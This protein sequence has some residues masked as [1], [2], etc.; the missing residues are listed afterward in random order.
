MKISSL[1]LYPV[2]KSIEEEIKSKFDK[3]YSSN[4]FLSGEENEKFEDEYAKFCNTKYCITCG[5]GLDALHLI[6]RA[7]EIGDEDEVIV[8]SNTFIA[9]AL[10]VTYAGAKPVLVEPD[11]NTYNINSELIENAITN[12]TKAIIAVHLYGHCADMDSINDIAKKYNLKVIEDAAQAHGAKYKGRPVGSLGDAAG[13]SF[14]PGKNLGALGDA[15]AIT[16]NDEILAKKAR[17]IANYGSSIKYHHEYK[18]FNS[19]LDEFQAGFLRIK[20]KHL[21]EWNDQRRKII[22]IYNDNIKNGDI[23]KPTTSC[24]ELPVWHQYVIRSAHRDFL[25][26]YLSKNEINTIIHYPI[27]IH[28]QKA[29]ADLRYRQGDLPIAEKISKEVLSIPIWPGMSDDEIQ[30][31]VDTLNEWIF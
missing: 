22:S 18:G 11:I 8:P 27:P 19:R 7:Y 4:W 9:T 25:Q 31:I 15:G 12:K 1:N 3:I 5:N 16:T 6:L 10:A 26:Y 20:L 24:Y 13:F 28:M 30:Y 29:Y 2:H 14:Y 17:A 21:N 23:L